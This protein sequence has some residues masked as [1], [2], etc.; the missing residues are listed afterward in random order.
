MS[1]QIRE[2]LFEIELGVSVLTEAG[3]R[4]LY[5]LADTKCYLNLR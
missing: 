3:I 1:V 4:A 5:F 2:H